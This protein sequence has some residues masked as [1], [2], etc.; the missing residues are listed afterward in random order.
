MVPR[1]ATDFALISPRTD[2]CWSVVSVP[3][4]SIVRSTSPSI[5]ISLRNLTEPVIETPRERRSGDCAGVDERLGCS[6]VTGTPASG[7]RTQ[8]GDICILLL[9]Q[10]WLRV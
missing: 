6:R 10:F 5:T 1:T 9:V 2:P 7:F 4:E 8:N 3:V